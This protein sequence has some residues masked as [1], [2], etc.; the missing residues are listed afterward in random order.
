MK[1]LHLLLASLLLF[2]A[3]VLAGADPA[4]PAPAAASAT[5]VPHLPPD[6]ENCATGW[7]TAQRVTGSDDGAAFL[8][9]SQFDQA[10]VAGRLLRR[11]LDLGSGTPALGP[12]AWDA[13]AVLDSGRT[14]PAARR[15]LTMGTAG[16]TINF[17]WSALDEAQRAALDPDGD[18]LGDARLAFLRG[19]R[20]R[21]GAPFRR[22]QSLLGELVRS[23]PL[24]VGAPAATG[25]GAD[26]LAFYKRYRARDKLVYVGAN[27]G[28]L[29]AF[30]W[31][32]GAERFAY[33]PAV[34]LPGL[35]QIAL[36]G[37]A[38]RA[39]VDGAPGQGEALIAGQ[40]RSVL[41]SGM[42]MGARGLFA[43]DVTDPA[44]GPRALWEFTQAD[45]AA[46]GHVHAP[47]AIVKLRIGGNN[48]GGAAAYR[49]FALCS[50]GLDPAD[51]AASGAL[52]LLALD[53]PPG[54]PWRRGENYFQLTAPAGQGAALAPPVLTFNAD[55]SAHTAYAGDLHG[56]LWRFPLDGVAGHGNGA[57]G[58]AGGVATALFRARAADGRPQPI[59][60]AARVVFAPG[61]GYLVLFGTGRT[62]ES[63]D[64]DPASFVPQSFY[65]VRDPDQAPW[66]TVAGRS[67][68]MERRLTPG[69][70]AGGG[71]SSMLEGQPFD[72]QGSGAGV[73][74]GW[75]FDYPY[76]AQAG[77]RSAG[78][79]ALAGTAVIAYSAAPGANR[80]APALRAYIVDSVT[81]LAHDRA[82]R[83][84]AQAATGRRVDGAAGNVGILLPLLLSR[85]QAEAAPTPT[86][87][88]RSLRSVGLFQFAAE[89][90]GLGLEQA[91]VAATT[92]RLSWREI[93][94]WQELH[95]AA[96]KPIGKP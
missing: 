52:F 81:G 27:D 44:A 54:A 96:A 87:A 61:G 42:G 91:A 73:R 30:G 6:K 64:L 78:P 21:E 85:A 83:P 35:R 95:D 71:A 9:E 34:L 80:C 43:L 38:P 7:Q 58:A 13:G 63:A 60:E 14:S 69:A 72:Y 46:I 12:A 70:A 41:L 5:T 4:A 47:P 57:G 55:G 24:L 86:G 67:A 94:N 32:D 66:S 26:Y 93:G 76:A 77:E 10:G 56:T 1:N 82:G 22:R 53:K 89:G 25:Q 48:A 49:Y 28:M 3:T 92:G 62:M 17:E 2:C 59:A 29:H 15:I 18:G 90:A 74:Q 11:S 75:Y 39:Y 50:N 36:A 8:L 19:E 40:W 31:A 45:D 20:G 23:M 51:G 33:I 37:S 84:A 79:P 68:L 88:V 65:G 16:A